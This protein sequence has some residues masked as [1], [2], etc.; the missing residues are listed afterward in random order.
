M[1]TKLKSFI[2]KDPPLFGIM[3]C[4]LLCYIPISF[5]DFNMHHFELGSIIRF[6]TKFYDSFS[7]IPNRGPGNPVFELFIILTYPIIGFKGFTILTA[8]ISIITLFF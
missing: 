8:L 6:I 7:Y 4:A 1:L 2:L 5:L 3:A